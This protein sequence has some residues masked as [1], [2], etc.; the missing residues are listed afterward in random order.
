MSPMLDNTIKRLVTEVPSKIKSGSHRAIMLILV[1][2]S[3][4]LHNQLSNHVSLDHSR[5]SP[6]NGDVYRQ[7]V[8]IMSQM[9]LK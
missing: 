5:V 9:V 7:A 6:A 3:M 2:L 1:I 8:V 4:G